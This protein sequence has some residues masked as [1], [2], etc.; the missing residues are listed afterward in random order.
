MENYPFPEFIHQPVMLSEIESIVVNRFPVEF[1]LK[2]GDIVFF[3]Q[4]HLHLLNE[5]NQSQSLPLEKRI[6]VWELLLEP[7]L[8][9]SFTADEKS[10]TASLLLELGID[11]SKAKKLRRFARCVGTANLFWWEWTHLGLF[12]LFLAMEQSIF[13]FYKISEKNYKIACQTARLAKLTGP[14]LAEELQSQIPRSRLLWEELGL[15]R[16]VPKKVI[17]DTYNIVVRA[18]NESH[19][20]YHNKHHL[21]KVLE[22]IEKTRSMAK[23][24]DTLFVAAV[25]HDFVYAPLSRTNEEDSARLCLE[26]TKVWNWSEVEKAKIT[27]LII[28][29]KKHLESD[30]SGDFGLLSNADLKIFAVPPKTYDFV[31]WKI[32]RE[33]EK[34]PWIIFRKKRMEFLEKFLVAAINKKVFCGNDS[35]LNQDAAANIENEL[36]KLKKANRI[37]RP[38]SF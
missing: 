25:F 26:L 22:D 37:F 4:D 2:N 29:T 27:S 9:T 36:T 10:K 8:D 24:W 34:V 16:K 15:A 28:S 13:N 17:D 35:A 32:Y 1:W 6:D 33:F 20:F 38:K 11:S 7:Y 23:S 30:R 3:P 18:Y 12:D 21:E 14:V 5:I 19:R 31:I